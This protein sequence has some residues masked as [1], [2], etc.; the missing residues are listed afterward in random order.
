MLACEADLDKL[1]FPLLASPKLD[2]VRAVVRGGVVYSRSNKPIPNKYVQ[3]LF[4]PYEHYDGE[5]I[6]GEPTAHD[7]YRKTTSGVMSVEGAPDVRF[8]VFDHVEHLSN[9]YQERQMRCI[10]FNK[11]TTFPHHQELIYTLDELLTYE[12]EVLEQG[13]EGLILRDPSAPYKMGRS[14]MKEGYLLKLKRFTDA[15]FEVVGFEERQHN[16]NEATTNELG[17]TK[18]SSHKAGKSGRGDLGALVLR[19]SPESTFS[20]GAGFTDSERAAIWASRD[21]CLGR[22]AKVKF[23]QIGMKDKPR[24]PVFLGFRDRMDT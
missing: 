18:R 4:S 3:A 6:V 8:Y 12:S 5:L 1:H 22:L 13:Y 19:L 23:F 11:K 9:P 17:R 7:V 2:G 21:E 24:H 10:R 15:E 16:G 20:V 14:T